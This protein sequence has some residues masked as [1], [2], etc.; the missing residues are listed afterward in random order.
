MLGQTAVTCCDGN[1]AGS[2]TTIFVSYP[3]GDGKRKKVLP[4]DL[5]TP[6]GDVVT[7][8]YRDIMSD[9]GLVRALRT[10][11][12]RDLGTGQ[13]P[14]LRWERVLKNHAKTLRHTLSPSQFRQLH[15]KTARRAS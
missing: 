1:I 13:H 7:G 10:C 6:A 15:L 4:R 11:P 5:L 12:R 14:D 3:S 2:Q 9:A 8:E